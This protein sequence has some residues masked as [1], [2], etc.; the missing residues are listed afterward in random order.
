MQASGV[1][2]LPGRARIF[3]C[4][5]APLLPLSGRPPAWSFC[6]RPHQR[7]SQYSRVCQGTASAS[8]P[9]PPGHGPTPPKQQMLIYVPPHPLIQ[10][11]LAIARNEATPPP[12]FRAAI[13]E[14]GRLLV[15]ELGRDWLP[16]MQQ[17]VYSPVGLADATFV[18][19]T[20][21]IKV[22]PILRAGLVL[23]EQ[24]ATVL[25]AQVTYHVGFVRNEET[26]Q[27]TSYLNKLPKSFTAEDHILVADPMLAT[28][29]TMVSVLED[30][31]SRGGDPSNIIVV[32]VVAAP[33]ALKKL[34]EKFVG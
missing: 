15:Y 4:L 12:I 31:V 34:S 11:W 32:C 22:V 9:P 20:Q 2:Q 33:P 23:V 7:Q 28:G 16:T 10:H 27:A 30:I 24:I 5:Q 14:L 25:P 29:G 26:L 3:S 8:P 13:A 18:D 17:Q 1:T 21:P 19:P 6:R